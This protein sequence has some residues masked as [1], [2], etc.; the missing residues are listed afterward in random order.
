MSTSF[1]DGGKLSLR[2]AAL[3]L[4]PDTLLLKEGLADCMPSPVLF[5]SKA[6]FLAENLFSSSLLCR[7]VRLM[8]L[9][10]SKAADTKL[11]DVGS[12][13]FF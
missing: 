1:R 13:K 5:P 11:P 6:S 8:S 12:K 4:Y 2:L 7:E 9:F 3:L 10:D